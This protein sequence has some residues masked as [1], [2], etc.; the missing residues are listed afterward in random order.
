M[1]GH[2]D[3]TNGSKRIRLESL[4]ECVCLCVC[5]CICMYVYVFVFMCLYL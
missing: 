4:R 5:V 3:G 2:I 1:D